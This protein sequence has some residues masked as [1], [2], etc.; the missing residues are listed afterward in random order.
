MLRRLLNLLEAGETRRVDDLAR[1]L[2][3]TPALVE[4]MLATLTRQG[5]LSPLGQTCS[6]ACG[7]CP[8]AGKCAAGLGEGAQVWVFASPPGE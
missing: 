8:L 4:A 5:Y 6:A 1:A 7:K 3:T 2:D